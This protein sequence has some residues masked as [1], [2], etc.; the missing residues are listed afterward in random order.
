[1]QDG[2]DDAQPEPSLR[3]VV[4][5]VAAFLLSQTGAAVARRF[6]ETLEEL[7]LDPRQFI[8][9]RTM[10]G[11]ERWTQ[12]SLA[13]QLQIPPSSMVGLIDQLESKRF[14]ARSVDAADRRVR[15]VVLTDEGRVVLGRAMAIAMGI[16]RAVCEGLSPGERDQL[17]DALERIADNLGLSAGVHPD[18]GEH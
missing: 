13:A 14:V 1:M 8:V 17:I 4:P 7:S 3:P 5:R 9:M 15:V 10:V 11:P 2:S 6:K 12:Q 18:L 16:E